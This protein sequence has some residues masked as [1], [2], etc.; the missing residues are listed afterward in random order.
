MPGKVL[1]GNRDPCALYG[2]MADI[3]RETKK[4][5]DAFGRSRHVAN[6]GHGLYPDIAVDNVKCFVDTVKEYSATLSKQ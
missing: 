2:S 3:R 6:L 5:I 4:M 1:Q